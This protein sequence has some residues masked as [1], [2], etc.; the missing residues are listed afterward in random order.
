[1]RLLKVGVSIIVLLL[2]MIIIVPIAS[3]ENITR[4]TNLTSL[5]LNSM[6]H[7]EEPYI[8]IDPIGNHVIGNVFFVNGTT[9]LPVS[10]KLTMSIEYLKYI[11][12]T[13]SK[14]DLGPPP[15]EGAYITAISISPALPGMNRW[16]ANVTD[17]TTELKSGDYLVQVDS[18]INESCNTSGCRIPDIST[19]AVFTLLPAN[20][21]IK[22]NLL[23]TTV[24]SP[25]TNVPVFPM[26]QSTSLPF[27]LLIAV[28]VAIVI[29]KPILG[30]KRD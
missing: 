17:I 24:Q 14:S 2:A 3:A 8:T 27:P 28:I 26:T 11:K 29:L 22:L 10:E 12:Q 9:N 16:S 21:S 30:K 4:G 19:T 7:P 6:V 23:Q 13:H 5:T 25:S 20:K 18:Q 15:D 1:M